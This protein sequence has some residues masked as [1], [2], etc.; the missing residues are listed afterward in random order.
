MQFDKEGKQIYRGG[1]GRK[2]NLKIPTQPNPANE[3]TLNTKY[4]NHG[5]YVCEFIFS[6]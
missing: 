2:I 4:G 5:E 1:G 3:K 6:K